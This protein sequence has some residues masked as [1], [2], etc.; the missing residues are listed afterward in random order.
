MICKLQY[1]FEPNYSDR[2]ISKLSG[3]DP[4]TGGNTPPKVADT[5]RHQGTIPEEKYPF[6]DNLDE[7]F[8]EVPQNLIDM[9]AKWLEEFELGYEYVNPSDLKI[10]LKRSPVG[11]AVSAWQQNADGEYIRFG[12]SN[13]WV[14]LVA[15]DQKD[16]PVIYDS[17]EAQLKTLSKDFRLD[18]PMLYVLKKKPK[19]VEQEYASG[20]HYLIAIKKVYR[21]LIDLWFYLF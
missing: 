16:R 19:S 1:D 5:I 18:F 3:T 11:C 4:S 17:Y 15:F 14:V 12:N 10:A 2:F 20:N 13:H 6:V 7:Y 9:G 8:K 21:F